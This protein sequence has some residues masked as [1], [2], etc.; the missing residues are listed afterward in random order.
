[1]EEDEILTIDVADGIQF[2]YD[3]IEPI[4]EDDAYNN[5]RIHLYGKFGKINAPMKIDVTT[6]DSIIPNALR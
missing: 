3:R 5:F 6:G 2:D 4:R 1:M